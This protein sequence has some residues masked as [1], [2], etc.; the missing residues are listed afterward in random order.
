MPCK[1]EPSKVSAV[2]W[3]EHM[4][5]KACQ[6]L[7]REQILQINGLDIYSDLYNWYA[8]HLLSDAVY[9]NKNFLLK[10]EEKSYINNA[11]EYDTPSLSLYD[12][13]KRIEIQK[14][15]IE[16]IYKEFNKLGL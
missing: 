16:R 7:T 8:E 5:C 4:L 10:D 12:K 2:E 15:E 3:L 9:Y 1:V 14:R 13:D 6:H 11:I